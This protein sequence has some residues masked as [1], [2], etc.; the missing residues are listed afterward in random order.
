MAKLLALERKLVESEI[1]YKLIVE[2]DFPYCGEAMAI[3]ISPTTKS[4]VKG[5]LGSLPL[6]K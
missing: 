5:V 1:P 6:L 2:P 4:A 3:G